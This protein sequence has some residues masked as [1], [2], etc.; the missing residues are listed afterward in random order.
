MGVLVAVA[1]GPVVGTPVA[2]LVLARLRMVKSHV[3]VRAASVAVG[4]VVAAV[5]AAVG[6]L[7]VT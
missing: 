4:A 3:G 2:T 5:G 7:V 6:T 1:V